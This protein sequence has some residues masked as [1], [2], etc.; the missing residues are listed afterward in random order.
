[1]C[2]LL[3]QALEYVSGGTRTP[4]P[5]IRSLMPYPLGYADR[6]PAAIRG[7]PRK[8]RADLAP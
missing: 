8:W 4:N 3:L 5:Q 2:D 6:L 1:M 7:T